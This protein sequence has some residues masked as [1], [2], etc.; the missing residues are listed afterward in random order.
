VTATV[1]PPP[2][3]VRRGPPPRRRPVLRFALA[4]GVVGLVL[5]GVAW[6]GVL[7]PQARL[8]PSPVSAVASVRPG[9][10]GGLLV[11]DL[12]TTD[13]VAVDV[14]NLGGTAVE[15]RRVVWELDRPHEVRVAPAGADGPPFVEVADLAPFAPFALPAGATRTIVLLSERP[16]PQ[17]VVASPLPDVRVE[18]ASPFGRTRTLEWSEGAGPPFGRPGC[19]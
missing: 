8:A 17:A 10:D 16:C 7:W 13:E 12:A 2:A 14:T 9:A 6:S 15:V 5:A 3:P 1:A 4:L 18:V 11:D 19:P